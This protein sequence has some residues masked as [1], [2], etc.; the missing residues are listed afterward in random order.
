M[1]VARTKQVEGSERCRE[2]S[3]GDRLNE[4]SWI[5]YIN[6]VRSFHGLVILLS[7]LN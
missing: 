5:F 1:E 7:I 6:I 3:P 2:E 4:L